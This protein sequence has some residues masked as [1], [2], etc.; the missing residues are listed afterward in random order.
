MRVSSIV[1]VAA[2]LCLTALGVSASSETPVKIR[3][4]QIGQAAREAMTPEM[5]AKGIRENTM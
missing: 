3:G 5:L 2:C 4:T 1:A